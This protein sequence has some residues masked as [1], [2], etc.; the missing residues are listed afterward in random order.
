MPAASGDQNGGLRPV[1]LEPVARVAASGI[2]PS[3]GTRPENG[4][5][6]RPSSP[7]DNRKIDQETRQREVARVHETLRNGITGVREDL[8]AQRFSAARERLN[9]LQET[10]VPYRADLMDDVASLRALDQEITS[11]QISSKTAALTRQQEEAGWQR[12]LQEIRGL[13]QDKRYPEAQTLANR[14]AGDSGVPEAIA[15]EARDLNAQAE[16][17]MKNIFHKATVKT[18]DE[19][20]KKPPR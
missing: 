7:P 16:Q 9:Q 20:V 1:D 14:L 13:L 2:R 8:E 6:Q 18:K 17:E 10:A 5:P 4:L 3:N 12:R 19:V 15:N 11:Q